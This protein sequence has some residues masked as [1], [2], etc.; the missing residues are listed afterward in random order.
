MASIL[1]HAAVKA[2]AVSSESFIAYLIFA[3]IFYHYPATLNEKMFIMCIKLSCS[4]FMLCSFG[5]ST[6]ASAPAVLSLMAAMNSIYGKV[7][8]ENRFVPSSKNFRY[9]L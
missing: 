1:I 5:I 2:V 3:Q 7:L 4:S 9:T 6:E 8:K